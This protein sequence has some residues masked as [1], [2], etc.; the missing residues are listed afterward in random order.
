MV[1][2]ARL[3]IIACQFC[4]ET[5]C[6]VYNLNMLQARLNY[7]NCKHCY[8]LNKITTVITNW[9]VVNFQHACGSHKNVILNE[10]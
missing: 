9:H 4:F 2:T 6:F 1:N 5:G 10:N 7:S 3:S 8:E